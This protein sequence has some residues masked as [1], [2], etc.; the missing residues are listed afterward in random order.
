MSGNNSQSA[1]E[2][3]KTPAESLGAPNAQNDPSNMYE[4]MTGIVT[5]HKQPASNSIYSQYVK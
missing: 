5:P 4:M 2:L 3:P 1:A